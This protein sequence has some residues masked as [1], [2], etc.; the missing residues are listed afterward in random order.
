MSSI[1]K[2]RNSLYYILNYANELPV[3]LKHIIHMLLTMLIESS[4]SF[5]TNI[6]SKFILATDNISLHLFICKTKLFSFKFMFLISLTQYSSK[7]PL[8]TV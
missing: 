3:T 2:H 6:T 4:K 5:L 1:S 8:T 7:V